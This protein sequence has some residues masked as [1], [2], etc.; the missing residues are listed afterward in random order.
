VVSWS[1]R[2]TSGE[3]I[4]TVQGRGGSWRSANAGTHPSYLEAN[5]P[6]APWSGARMGLPIFL[7]VS[8]TQA[9]PAPP[10]PRGPARP[11]AT[12]ERKGLRQRLIPP[13]WAGAEE[14]ADGR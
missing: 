8:R 12:K 14:A 10:Q 4:A 11:G 7:G 3:Q 5:P 1:Q 9:G 2:G 6:P 13:L